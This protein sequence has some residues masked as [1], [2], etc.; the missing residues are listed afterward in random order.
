M[1]RTDEQL[2]AHAALEGHA[3]RYRVEIDS[4]GWPIIHAK[5][6]AA[7]EWYDG[8]DLAV[9]VTAER[10]IE[11]R[12]RR[13]VNLGARR[14]QTGDTDARL[15]FP[16]TSLNIIAKAIRARYRAQSRASS[17]GRSPQAM[18][19]LTAARLAAH[20]TEPGT[21]RAA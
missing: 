1:R 10:L 16:V 5:A 3:G 2:T 20:R 14:H 11:A 6:G 19:A 7:I 8:N 18:R 9:Y 21:Q 4:E 13:L 15:I 17:L 12:V